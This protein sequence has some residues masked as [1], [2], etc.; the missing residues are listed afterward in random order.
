MVAISR[1]R[2][3]IGGARE[4]PLVLLGD[5][6]PP[7]KGSVL[8]LLLIAALHYPTRQVYSKR[9]DISQPSHTH[10]WAPTRRWDGTDTAL[11]FD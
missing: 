8:V 10:A 3:A 5:T 11:I 4:R 1:R 7:S 9:F 2:D 6:A